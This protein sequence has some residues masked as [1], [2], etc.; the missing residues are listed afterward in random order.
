MAHVA[1][2]SSLPGGPATI[3][4]K[5]AILMLCTFV[6][7][8]KPRELVSR[9]GGNLLDID[10]MLYGDFTNYMGPKMEVPTIYVW[11]IFSGLNF[12]EYPH[13]SCGLKYGTV[14]LAQASPR[15]VC[16]LISYIHLDATRD[17]TGCCPSQWCERWFIK[18]MNQFVIS[19]I[20]YWYVWT[21]L[22]Y[23]V[24]FTMNHI[25]KGLLS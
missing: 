20:N 22:L 23:H 13:N 25:L 6:K 10:V 5:S 15:L 24:I 19:T 16:K 12:R 3:G 14:P 7:A 9:T 18:L 11:P 21:S 4:A 17:L 2:K 1:V 8:E